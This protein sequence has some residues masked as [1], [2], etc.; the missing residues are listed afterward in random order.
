MPRD[1][2]RGGSR[3]GSCANLH[4]IRIP[5][6]AE[7]HVRAG[8]GH[9]K[10]QPP[11]PRWA[12][13]ESLKQRGEPSAPPI[14]WG[15]ISCVDDQRPTSC[16]SS[17]CLRGRDTRAHGDE[18][19][20][21]AAVGL[22]IAPTIHPDHPRPPNA[23]I[24]GLPGARRAQA[25]EA[26]GYPPWL[27]DNAQPGT[28]CAPFRVRRGIHRQALRA[29]RKVL[30]RVHNLL[31]VRLL[32]VATRVPHDDVVRRAPALRS[33]RARSR[34]DGRRERAS[35]LHALAPSLR[36]RQPLAAAQP[37]HR[38]SRRASCSSFRASSNRVLILAMFLPVAGPA[39]GQ[40]RQP[41]ARGDAARG[42]SWVS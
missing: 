24:D 9:S 18:G 22:Q 17:A 3:P 19:R 41:D 25:L 5:R 13:A 33:S 12:S 15:P 7:F 10:R 16:T 30:A 2:M 21:F 39:V 35:A 36:L 29:A 1:V 4:Q 31:E 27:V 32:H 38:P 28:S 6:Y 37:A 23:G 26:G 34:R 11:Q 14:S 40:H 8:R 42:C 20:P